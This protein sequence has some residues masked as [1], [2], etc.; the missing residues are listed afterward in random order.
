M[1]NLLEPRVREQLAPALE[2][3]IAAIA[4]AVPAFAPIAAGIRREDHAACLERSPELAED[5]RQL[6][7]G[8]V[9]ERC[10]REDA[11]KASLGELQREKVL[12]EHFAPGVG[13]RHLAERSAAVEPHDL[14]ADRAEIGEVSARTATEVEEGE[15][16]GALEALE[17]RGVVLGDVVVPC[18]FPEGA[19]GG[20]VVGQRAGGDDGEARVHEEANPNIDDPGRVRGRG[21]CRRVTT[22]RIG[23]ESCSRIIPIL[24]KTLIPFP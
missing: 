20:L 14:M 2:L 18:A 5:A 11:V 17:E 7:G 21:R 24:A 1:S 22:P 10:V 8:N 9:K 4:R 13:A 19:G 12:V 15:W 23:V 6:G 16:R 3:E